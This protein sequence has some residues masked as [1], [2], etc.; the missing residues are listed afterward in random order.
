M[1]ARSAITTS[2]I[3][4][5]LLAATGLAGAGLSAASQPAQAATVTHHARVLPG[6]VHWTYASRAARAD[7]HGGPAIILWVGDSDQSAL[8]CKKNAVIWPPD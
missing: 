2:T 5:A 4:A 6:W 1:S 8:I 7:C 3:I